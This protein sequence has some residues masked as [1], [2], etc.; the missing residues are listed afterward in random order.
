MLEK[1][2]IPAKAGTQITI[3][4][5]DS[6]DSARWAI[7]GWLRHSIWVPAFAGMSG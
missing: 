5:P 2:L 4:V 1:P 3:S 7:G 6:L